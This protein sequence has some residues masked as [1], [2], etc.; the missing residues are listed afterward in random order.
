MLITRRLIVWYVYD[1]NMNKKSRG[2]TIIQH[3]RGWSCS[4]ALHSPGRSVSASSIVTWEGRY[5]RGF[6]DRRKTQSAVFEIPIVILYNNL[7]N[8]NDQNDMYNT[9]CARITYLSIIRHFHPNNNV[10]WQADRA[11][12]HYTHIILHYIQEIETNIKLSRC[13]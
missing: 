7:M 3:Y 13:E 11:G 10:I 9:A 8:N 12:G 2:Y 5:F 6:F 1:W 4:K